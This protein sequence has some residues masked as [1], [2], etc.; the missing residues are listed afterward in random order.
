MAD[1]PKTMTISAG[2]PTA[3]NQSMRTAGERGPVL[4]QD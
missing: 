3:D 1:E 4:L 2:A